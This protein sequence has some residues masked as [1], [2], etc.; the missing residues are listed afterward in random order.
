MVSLYLAPGV[1]ELFKWVAAL[2]AMAEL[3]SIAMTF[4]HSAV[5]LAVSGGVW[6]K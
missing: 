6:L 4:R 5:I 1:V 3:G 2:F